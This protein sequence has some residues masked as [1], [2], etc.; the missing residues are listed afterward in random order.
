M[1][2][3][4]KTYKV[5]VLL[6]DSVDILDFGGPT[7]VLTS[8]RPNYEDDSPFK[9]H[10]VGNNPSRADVALMFKTKLTLNKAAKRVDDFN[11]LVVRGAQISRV[12]DMI[13]EKHHLIELIKTFDAQAPKAR[14]DDCIILSICPSTLFRAAVG[15]IKDIK[16]MMRRWYLTPSIN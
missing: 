10:H 1:A 13:K 11:V 3:V 5:A 2:S 16:T 15:V 12:T 14:E 4:T 6:F 8:T 7:E 9:I